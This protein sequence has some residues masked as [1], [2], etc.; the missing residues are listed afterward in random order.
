MLGTTRAKSKIVYPRNA[1][2]ARIIS[3]GLPRDVIVSLYVPFNPSHLVAF[4][5]YSPHMQV[6]T[7]LRRVQNMIQMPHDDCLPASYR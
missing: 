1:K 5:M 2:L 3:T 7:E 6:V 4:N